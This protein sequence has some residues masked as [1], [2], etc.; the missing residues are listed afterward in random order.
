[1]CQ[2]AEL[3]EELSKKEQRWT[4]SAQRSRERLEQLEVENAELKEEVRLLERK[5][6][7]SLQ[8]EVSTVYCTR[9]NHFVQMQ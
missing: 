5:R 7:D 1:M 9:E 2:L 3:R 6:M 4:A 8:K